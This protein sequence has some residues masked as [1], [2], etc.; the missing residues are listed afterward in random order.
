MAGLMTLFRRHSGF[1]TNFKI[2]MMESRHIWRNTECGE[3]GVR[4]ALAGA[5]SAGRAQKR[6]LRQWLGPGNTNK[7]V[8]GTSW[9]VHRYTTLPVLPSHAHPGYTHPAT[10][11][12][13]CHR[14][15][16][17]GAL[18]HAHMT[19]LMRPKE[20]LGVEY[21]QVYRSVALRMA[22]A[23]TGVTLRPCCHRAR[24]TSSS[25]SLLAWALVHK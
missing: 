15:L 17:P 22:C 4:R 16:V 20:I 18:G 2:Y 23:A 6:G 12:R 11:A 21:A 5:W 19:S 24:I 9:V 13:A 1:Y 14:C 10:R 7:R 8:S 25:G 3:T